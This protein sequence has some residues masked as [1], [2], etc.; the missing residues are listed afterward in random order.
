M[1]P[2]PQAL[3]KHLPPLLS[4]RGSVT[5]GKSNSTQDRNSLATS[6]SRNL[7]CANLAHPEDEACSQKHHDFHMLPN[8]SLVNVPREANNRA[9]QL[10]L[11]NLRA[12]WVLSARLGS[13]QWPPLALLC[14]HMADVRKAA[15]FSME[16][17]VPR[18]TNENT[19]Y[20]VIFSYKG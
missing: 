8:S 20:S 17:W 14:V 19:N 12:R 6:S 11:G 18:F 15:L 3:H 16:S 13:F 1:S 9:F 7:T 4:G 10:L 5:R 2:G